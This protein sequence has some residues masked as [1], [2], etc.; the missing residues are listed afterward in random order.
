[1]NLSDKCFHNCLYL[2]E[3]EKYDNTAEITSLIQNQNLSFTTIR[4]VWKQKTQK[5]PK[6]N[7]TEVSFLI[8]VEVQI[9]Q[10]QKDHHKPF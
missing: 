4:P 8:T 1:M 3:V 10:Q 7:F 5:S 6:A 9:V 2:A